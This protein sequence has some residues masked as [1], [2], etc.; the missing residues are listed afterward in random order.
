MFLAHMSVK[1]FVFKPS[2]TARYVMSLGVPGWMGPL[3]IAAE[4]AGGLR[5]I[6]GILPRY[7][8]WHCSR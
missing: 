7:T 5:L 6:L 2:G 1:L 3:T 4:V 8:A